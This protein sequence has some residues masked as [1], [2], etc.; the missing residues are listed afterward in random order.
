M[1]AEEKDSTLVRATCLLLARSYETGIARAYSP[2][3][4]VNYALHE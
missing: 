3:K 1:L 2:K 4:E